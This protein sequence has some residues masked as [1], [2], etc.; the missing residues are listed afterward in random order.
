[1][2]FVTC[3]FCACWG[4]DRDS[5][6]C[7]W[8]GEV[9]QP[10]ATSCGCL[11]WHPAEDSFCFSSFFPAPLLPDKFSQPFWSFHIIILC[12][13]VEGWLPALP[14][15]FQWDAHHLLL[16][17]LGQQLQTGGG[18]KALPGWNTLLQ[19][20]FSYRLLFW[21]MVVFP[22]QSIA[23]FR[24]KKRRNLKPLKRELAL[25]WL[26]LMEKLT[27]PSSPTPICFGCLG[28]FSIQK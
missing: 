17:S 4:R 7:L 9:A 16:A 2:H 19:L 3:W 27:S 20:L 25:L 15:S 26:R 22:W 23:W 6:H 10:I 18:P 11:C 14:T 28:N 12:F 24:G 13:A 1:M 21:L 5:W 8:A